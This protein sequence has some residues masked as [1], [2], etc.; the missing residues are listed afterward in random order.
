MVLPTTL[1]LG[2]MDFSIVSQAIKALHR[3]SMKP[4]ALLRFSVDPK[5]LLEFFQ[6]L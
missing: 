4:K 5:M 1:S 2:F 6:F 3:F